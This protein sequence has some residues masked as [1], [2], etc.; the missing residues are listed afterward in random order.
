MS[1][2]AKSPKL[3][4]LHGNTRKQNANELKK[5]AK[6]EERMKMP[7]DKLQPPPLLDKKGREAFLFV[8]IELTEI[9]VAWNANL[10]AIVLYADF[11]SQYLKYQRLINLIISNKIKV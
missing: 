10:H 2:L 5:R 8:V 7:T 1:M 4:L 3:K 6:N 9:D 11:Y